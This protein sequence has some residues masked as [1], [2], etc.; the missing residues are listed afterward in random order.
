MKAHDL[1]LGETASCIS[2]HIITS[3][4]E[5]WEPTVV[6]NSFQN[7]KNRKSSEAVLLVSEIKEY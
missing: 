2:L 4:K 1:G 7:K 3:G 5:S 6:L